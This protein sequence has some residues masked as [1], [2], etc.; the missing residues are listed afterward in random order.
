MSVQWLERNCIFYYDE[1]ITNGVYQI[2]EVTL[3]VFCDYFSFHMDYLQSTWIR[4]VLQKP[5]KLNS[6]R[7]LYLSLHGID[8]QMHEFLLR[9]NW[10]SPFPQIHVLPYQLT[11][12]F[13]SSFDQYLSYSSLS[14]SLICLH[15]SR[16]LS[17]V[18]SSLCDNTACQVITFPPT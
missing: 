13:I 15:Q 10:P 17:K 1:W 9:C 12:L 14:C 3:F 16:Y 7:C 4:G 2:S 11:H 8:D 5:P 18:P 6:F